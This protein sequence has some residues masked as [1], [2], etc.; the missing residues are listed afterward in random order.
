MPTYEVG[1]LLALS[2]T[3]PIVL[4]LVGLVA[5]KHA[6][7]HRALAYTISMLALVAAVTA[8]V[9]F[10]IYVITSRADW[11]H[12]GLMRVADVVAGI[13]VIALAVISTSVV[14]PELFNDDEN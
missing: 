3:G 6:E 11:W 5:V 7:R 12:H 2:L 8:G 14:L 10:N 1:A 9:G 4:G 13:I